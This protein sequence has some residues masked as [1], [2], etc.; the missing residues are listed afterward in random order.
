MRTAENT[1]KVWDPVIRI[2][3][4]TLVTAFFTAYFTED[5]FLTAHVWAGYVIGV[6]VCFRLLWGLVGSDHARF[7]DFMRPP[8]AIFR[9]LTDLVRGQSKRY[10]G[11]NPAGAGMILTLLIFLTATVFSGIVLYGME[12]SAGPLAAWVTEN[13][14]REEI[15]EELHEVFANLTLLLVVLH[16]IG[17]IFSSR[18]HRENLAKAMITGRKK[19]S[20][21]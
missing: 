2:G 14:D 5:E 20:D 12:E 10:L 4:W 17:V 9:Y 18:A 3:H 16:V 1:I 7:K 6:V 11:H 19:V 8:A 21:E 15:W 13:S